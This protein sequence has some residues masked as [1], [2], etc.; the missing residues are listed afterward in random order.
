MKLSNFTQL[1]MPFTQLDHG[2]RNGSGARPRQRK[3]AA[4][5][6]PEV[7]GNPSHRGVRA[8]HSDGHPLDRPLSEIQQAFKLKSTRPRLKLQHMILVI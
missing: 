5:A 6:R 4:G 2:R 3:A 8:E 7:R 1:R